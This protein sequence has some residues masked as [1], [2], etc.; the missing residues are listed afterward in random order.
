MDALLVIDMQN[1]F[2][3]PDGALYRLTGEPLIN[4]KPTIDANRDLIE[5]ARGAD[6]PI[7]FTRHGFRPGYADAGRMVK[8]TFRTALDG[9]LLNGSWDFAVVDELAATE[10]DLYVDK[11]RMDAFYNTDLELLLRGLSAE[12]LVVSGIV[13]NACVETTTRSAAM[14]DF[15]VTV[16]RDCCTTYSDADQTASNEILTRYGLARIATLDDLL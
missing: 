7:V 11:A 13:S 4:I 14:R 5:A 12:R 3:H 1:S 6:V 15:D 2:L 16:L 10:S 9:A 8:E